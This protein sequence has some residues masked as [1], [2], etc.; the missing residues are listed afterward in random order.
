MSLAEIKTHLGLLWILPLIGIAVLLIQGETLL[1][2]IGGLLILYSILSAIDHFKNN[3]VI[4]KKVLEIA[5]VVLFCVFSYLKQSTILAILFAIYGAYLI[6]RFAKDNII[7]EDD[8]KPE[9]IAPEEEVQE[10]EIVEAEVVEE[11]A[12]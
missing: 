11:N 12:K 3:M 10:P 8:M 5:V 1:K 4:A 9:D 2:I 7:I 6:F